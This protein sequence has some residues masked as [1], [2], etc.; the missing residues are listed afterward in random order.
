M[1]FGVRGGRNYADT[2]N[3]IIYPTEKALSLRV[4]ENPFLKGVFIV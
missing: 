2:H 3:R 4:R 1:A